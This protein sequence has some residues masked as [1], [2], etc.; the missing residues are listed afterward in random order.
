MGTVRQVVVRHGSTELTYPADQVWRLAAP[1]SVREASTPKLFITPR[2]LL[3]AEKGYK[4]LSMDYSQLEVRIMAHFSED[5]RFVDILSQDGDV[6]RHMAAGWLQKPEV[7]VT[8]EERNGAKKVCYGLIYGMGARRLAT[9]LGISH[10]Q[11]V[12]F[13][14]SFGREYAGVNRWILDC[15]EQARVRGYVETLHGRRRFLPELAALRADSRARAERQSVNT[16]CQ[17][18]AADLMKIAMLKMHEAI[19]AM[20]RS[21]MQS[22]HCHSTSTRSC[23][24]PARMLLQIHDEMLLEVEE[25]RLKEVIDVVKHAMLN[26]AKLKVPLKVKWRHGMSWGSL[27]CVSDPD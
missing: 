21:H 27:D 9:E 10:E 4:L 7:D 23:R 16:V 3:V 5:E 24:W 17:A 14:T 15:Q 25:G 26:A 2:S 11:A 8:V 13:Q 12:D 22:G 20:P 19:Q 18:S 6:F 1:V